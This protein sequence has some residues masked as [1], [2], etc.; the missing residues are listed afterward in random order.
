MSN[1]LLYYLGFSHFPAIDPIKFKKLLCQQ[2]TPA[3][4]YWAKKEQLTKI[5]SKNR[6]DEICFRD[7][8]SKIVLPVINSALVSVEYQD[9]IRPI[10]APNKPDSI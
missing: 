2:K 6:Y 4:A 10:A 7:E 5:I 9:K 3:K 1:D 8:G